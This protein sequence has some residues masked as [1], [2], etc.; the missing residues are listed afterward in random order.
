M[1]F[2]A[3]KEDA[4]PPVGHELGHLPSTARRVLDQVAYIELPLEPRGKLRLTNARYRTWH[5][6]WRGL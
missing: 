4:R 1:L 6:R 2:A 5:R 3:V